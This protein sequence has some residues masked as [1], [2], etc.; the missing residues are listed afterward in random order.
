CGT[1]GSSRD[2]GF[3]IR[4]SGDTIRHSGADLIERVFL[5]WDEPILRAAAR[6]LA[7]TRA[8]EGALDLRSL[9][10]GVPGARA[11]R[12]LKELLLEE[13][14][15][16]ELRYAPPRVVTLG[17]LPE[18]FYRPSRPLAPPVVV[19]RVWAEALTAAADD[20]LAEVL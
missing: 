1:G 13:A 9:V 2:S 6:H 10:A 7:E 17:G 11:G 15:R 20:R 16:R 12:R 18:L 4:H 3:G 14:E 8:A 5:G 19:R